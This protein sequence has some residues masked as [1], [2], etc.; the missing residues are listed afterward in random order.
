[1]QNVGRFVTDHLSLVAT[2]SSSAPFT[3]HFSP[4]TGLRFAPLRPRVR[5]FLFARLLTRSLR[6]DRGQRFWYS[7]TARF[8]REH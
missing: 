5:F 8:N 3:S 2:C 7:G 1:V 4:F 6:V